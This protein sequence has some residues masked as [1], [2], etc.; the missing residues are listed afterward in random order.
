[1]ADLSA[2]NAR[3]EG[4]FFASDGSFPFAASKAK[5]AERFLKELNRGQATFIGALHSHS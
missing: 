1:M 3:S 5:P 2:A 4:M